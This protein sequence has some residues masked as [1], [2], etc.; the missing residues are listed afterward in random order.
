MNSF[1]IIA[2]VFFTLYKDKYQQSLRG[3]NNIH[4]TSN[5]GAVPTHANTEQ[6][7]HDLYASLI[8]LPFVKDKVKTLLN[9]KTGPVR[10]QAVGI[11]HFGKKKNWDRGEQFQ[12]IL[13]KK[14]SHRRQC[15]H[16]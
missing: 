10:C 2:L 9:C 7:L 1:S 3:Q 11:D 15:S 5:R 13:L 4:H 14:N 12:Q 6:N 8:K 16:Y